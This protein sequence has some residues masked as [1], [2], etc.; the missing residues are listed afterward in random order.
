MKRYRHI[1]IFLCVACSFS[2]FSQNTSEAA[3][4][5]YRKEDYKKS[6]DL[7]EQIVAQGLSEKRE[8]AE[9]YYNLGNA[10]F[11]DNQIAKAILH[12]ERALLLK[13][14]DSDIRHNLRFARTRIEDRID[15]TGS[16][17]LVNLINKLQNR[18]TSNTWSGIAIVFFL[19]FLVC[20]GIF[21]FIRSIWMKKTA[22][23]TGLVVLFLLIV[24]NVFAFRQKNMLIHRDTGIVM[25]V[26]ASVMTSPDV[27]SKELFRLHAGTKVK[28]NR[29]DGNWYEVEIANGSVGWTSKDNVEII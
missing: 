6:I 7:Y 26:S 5:A 28:L 27:N 3:S 18:F 1:F 17:F 29:T 22:F 10:Y 23:Y 14:A 13:P 20:I 2:M 25:P 11:R 15:T 16:L 24:C 21:L 12:Y 19:L 8:S 9:I 4:E